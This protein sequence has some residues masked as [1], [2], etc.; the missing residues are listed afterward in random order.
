M[1]PSETRRAVAAAMS[2]ASTLDLTVDDA[3]VLHD[4]NRLVLS[5][6]PCDVVARVARV[7]HPHGSAELEVA[8]ARRLAETGSP[9]AG[10]E[11]R[12]EPRV[13]V[14][15]SFEISLWTYYEPVPSRGLPPAGYADLL[16]RLH[17]GMRKID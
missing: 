10:P 4:S 6:M 5:L 15:D 3:I 7:V 8:V 17:A 14:R 12:V 1:Q 16:T 2:T 13:Y 11:P 9:V